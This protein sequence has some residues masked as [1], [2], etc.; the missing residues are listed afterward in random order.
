MKTLLEQ[1]K[2]QAKETLEQ[3]IKARAAKQSDTGALLVLVL[4]FYFSSVSQTKYCKFK[5]N[6]GVATNQSQTFRSLS[7]NSQE[8]GWDFRDPRLYNAR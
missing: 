2:D 6:V 7:N 4:R 3:P 5:K 8:A 1:W